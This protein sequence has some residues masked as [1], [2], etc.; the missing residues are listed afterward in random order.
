MKKNFL[1][2][3][4]YTRSSKYEGERLIE[5]FPEVNPEIGNLILNNDVI[6][7]TRNADFNGNVRTV[8]LVCDGDALI[9]GS[10]NVAG[11]LKCQRITCKTLQV[12][13]IRSRSKFFIRLRNLFLNPF[14]YLF[15][16]YMRY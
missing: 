10:I 15:K 13:I 4:F 2:D 5:S 11:D 16:G 9:E 7:F 12:E 14:T 1:K 8:S 3:F 6:R